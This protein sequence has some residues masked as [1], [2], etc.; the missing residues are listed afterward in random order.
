MFKPRYL[1]ALTAA[2]LA[3]TGSVTAAVNVIGVRYLV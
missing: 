3:T 2:L 1:V